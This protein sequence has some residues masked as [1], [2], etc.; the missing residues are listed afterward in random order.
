VATEQENETE[1]N[2]MPSEGQDFQSPPGNKSSESYLTKALK[3]KSYRTISIMNISKLNPG[4]YK[5]NIC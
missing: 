4:I 3:E 1:C 2:V 5:N